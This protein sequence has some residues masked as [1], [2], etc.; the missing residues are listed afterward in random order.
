MKLFASGL[1]YLALSSQAVS[2]Q[3]PSWAI[4]A[5]NKQL[6][7]YSHLAECAVYTAYT[8]NIHLELLLS[9]LLV[10]NGGVARK[11]PNKD[12]SFDY[13]VMQINT[14]RLGEIEHLGVTSLDLM[15]NDCLAVFVGGYLISKELEKAP[16][17][18]EGVG[19]YHYRIGGRWPRH[20]HKY[21]E[22]V[23]KAW[24]SLIGVD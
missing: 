8:H 2:N 12:G 5:F 22:N 11:N 18:W 10:E 21:R 4:N 19:N 1:L 16:S 24:L 14:V 6:N 17:F 3:V 15:E 23:Y 7:A 9:V 13:G 20:H